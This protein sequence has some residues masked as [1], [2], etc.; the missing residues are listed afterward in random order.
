[1]CQG[2]SIGPYVSR[3]RSV[4]T[5][6]VPRV[7]SQVRPSPPHSGVTSCRL[8]DLTDL[9]GTSTLRSVQ[10]HLGTGPKDPLLRFDETRAAYWGFGTGRRDTSGS[11]PH[12]EG[13][14]DSY[15]SHESWVS[16]RSLMTLPVLDGLEGPEGLPLSNTESRY[17]V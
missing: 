10:R 9:P 6:T 12:R 13:C 8:P 7:S 17:S 15:P 11:F 4:R 1:M 16:V 5:T 14:L 2:S 3:S